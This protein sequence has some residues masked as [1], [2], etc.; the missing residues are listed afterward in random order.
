M[1]RASR[2]VESH[3]RVT[4][5]HPVPLGVDIYLQLGIVRRAVAAN[6]VNPIGKTLE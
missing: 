1:T 3:S 6:Q 2:I 4:V 5:F